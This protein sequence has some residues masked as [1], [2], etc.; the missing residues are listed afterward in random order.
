MTTGK[1]LALTIWTFV[2]K[3][4][5]LKSIKKIIAEHSRFSHLTAER[6]S[7]LLGKQREN[8]LKIQVLLS[9]VMSWV[10]EEGRWFRAFCGIFNSSLERSSL[11]SSPARGFPRWADGRPS[12]SIPSWTS[13]THS[14]LF[15]VDSYECR[16]KSAFL[17]L[18]S[19]PWSIAKGSPRREFPTVY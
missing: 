16:H 15:S 11:Y 10:R 7:L 5:S 14:W 2:G 9:R 13:Q 6:V 8:S 3:V 18:L 12:L 17:V 4:M 19:W 1:T